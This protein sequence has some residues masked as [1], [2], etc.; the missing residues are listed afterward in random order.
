MLKSLFCNDLTFRV[1][2]G[3]QARIFVFVDFALPEPPVALDT[4]LGIIA[5]GRGVRPTRASWFYQIR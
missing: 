2:Q 1:R 4:P 3:R 5:E